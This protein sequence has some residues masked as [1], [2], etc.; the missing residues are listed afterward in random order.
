M[1]FSLVWFETR[2]Q[3][4]QAG[5][6]LIVIFLLQY[7]AILLQSPNGTIPHS[8]TFHRLNDIL[9]HVKYTLQKAKI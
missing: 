4:A 5:F 7:L 8:A 3:D 1:W 6:K 9:T 2:L